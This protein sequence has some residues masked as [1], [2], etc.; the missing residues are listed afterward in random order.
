M[1]LR[2]R[3]TLTLVS[4]AALA[5]CSESGPTSSD[6]AP[7]TPVFDNASD[8]AGDHPQRRVFE[9][10]NSPGARNAASRRG[11]GTGIVN[12]GGPVLQAATKVVA[13]YWASAPVYAGGP[14]VGTSS[15][16]GSTGDNSLVG[17]FLRNL[18]GSP[19]FNINS[20]YT[21]SAGVK[22]ANI[23]NY[24]GFWANATNAPSATSTATISDAQMIAMLQSGFNSGALVY[25]ANTLYLIFTAGKANLGGGFGTQYCGYHTNGSV[26]IGGVAKSALYSAMPYDYAYP[27]GCTSGRSSPNGD[28]AADAEVSVL[29]HEI[30]E[31]TTDPFGNAWYDTRGYENADKCAWNYGTTANSNMVLGG[32]SFLVQLNWVNS[33]SG[34]CVISWP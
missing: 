3:T 2:M 27:A 16:S 22:I 19:Y 26:T 30:E 23:V 6:P 33:G 31:T 13:I 34:G 20:T 4:L 28:P 15:T 24:T 11:S 8:Q 7:A 5:A 25:D 17:H 29:A 9:L 1:A 14:A 32:K 21:N 18:G 10:R 12:H